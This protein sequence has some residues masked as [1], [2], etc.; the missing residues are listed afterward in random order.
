MLYNTGLEWKKSSNKRIS[1]FGMSGV[2]KTFIANILRESKEW[3]HY[4]IDY[5]IGT[6]YLGEEIVDNFKKEAMKIPFLREHL[7]NDS[8][9]LSSNITFNNLSPL[10][11]F[12]GKPGKTSS[13]GIDFN[14]YVL[15]QRKHYN[16]EI[17]ATNDTALFSQKSI[18]IYG[19][20]HFISDTS[21]S[22]CEVVNPEDSQDKILKALQKNTLPVWVKGSQN[23]TD[24]LLERF[25][26]SP[27]PMFYNESFLKEKW[28]KYL[29]VHNQNPDEVEPDNFMSYGF[30]ALI[31]R[32]LPIYE[33]IATNWGVT[34]Q[35]TDITE[36]TTPDDLIE[37][38]ADAVDKKNLE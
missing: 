3:F 15:R 28:A 22:L 37:I 29:M 24:Q 16:A 8:I 23:Q 19:Y 4:S 11:G 17:N 7:L 32:R 10:S 38:I 14:E 9:Y 12:L 26:K 5:R 2:G 30:N 13:G 36:L 31:L 20:K 18:D 25:K 35:A 33:K 34:L 1:L 21:G 27:K 6:R